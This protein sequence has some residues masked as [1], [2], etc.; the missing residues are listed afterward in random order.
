MEGLLLVREPLPSFM[1]GREFSQGLT[2][3][4]VHVRDNNK[5]FQSF[6]VGHECTH[7]FAYIGLLACFSDEED[8]DHER[9]EAGV[10]FLWDDC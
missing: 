8:T 1:V 2:E 7:Q 5:S 3:L 4:V 9:V 10:G 6:G